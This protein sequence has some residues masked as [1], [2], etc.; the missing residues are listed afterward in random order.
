MDVAAKKMPMFCIGKEERRCKM[1][2]REEEVLEHIANRYPWAVE[3]LKMRD[4][5]KDKGSGHL[6]INMRPI[7]PVK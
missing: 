3:K 7:E 4:M 1:Y 5:L 2:D 6:E